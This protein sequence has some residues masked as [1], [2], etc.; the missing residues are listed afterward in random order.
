MPHSPKANPSRK[1]RRTGRK[2]LYSPGYDCIIEG[3]RR[4]RRETGMSQEDLADRLGRTQLWVSRCER[5][6]RRVDLLEFL[7]FLLGCDADPHAFIDQ[8]RAQITLP[9]QG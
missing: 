8:I 6:D 5:G 3:L 4:V 7:E 2:S 1:S 9:P